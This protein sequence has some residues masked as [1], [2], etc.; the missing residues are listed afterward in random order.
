MPIAYLT[1]GSVVAAAGIALVLSNVRAHRQHRMDDDLSEA[2][3]QFF[4]SQYGRRMQTSALTVTFGALIGLC[5]YLK[6][7]EM[8]IF[9]TCYV[10]GLLLLALWLIL[11]ALS[12]VVASRV[13]AGKLDRRNRLVRKSLQQALDEVRQAHGL[14]KATDQ[15]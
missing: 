12:D 5:G 2:D 3:Q 1:F 8:P 15:A 4:D 13:Y 7:E 6:F 11:L 9:S 14:D 10:I